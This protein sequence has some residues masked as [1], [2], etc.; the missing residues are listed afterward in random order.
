M[1][2]LTALLIAGALILGAGVS[3]PAEAS[4]CH[5]F[6]P[7]SWAILDAQVA[8]GRIPAIWLAQLHATYGVCPQ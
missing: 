1:K 6:T 5:C 4:T 3:A 2:R 8:S 7:A